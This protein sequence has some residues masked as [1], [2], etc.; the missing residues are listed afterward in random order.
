MGTCVRLVLACVVMVGACLLGQSPAFGHTDLVASFP[1]DGQTLSAPPERLTL[2][3]ATPVV[4]EQSQLVVRDSEGVVH[5]VD[6][7]AS[8]TGE[9]L[10]AVMVPGGPSGAWTVGYRMLSIDGHSVKGSISFSVGDS[11]TAVAGVSAS[12][13]FGWFLLGLPLVLAVGFSLIV[14][15]M[16]IDL[17]APR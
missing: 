12:V 7:L 9:V 8:T 17:R 2:E 5:Q 11:Q 3:F 6:V 15:L 14:R 13:R 16:P 4:H 1:A 10:V